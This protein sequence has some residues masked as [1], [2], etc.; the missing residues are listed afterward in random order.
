[1]KKNVIIWKYVLFR[2]TTNLFTD[3]LSMKIR[4]FLILPQTF[5]W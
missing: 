3:F 5:E 2:N 4:L 1:M